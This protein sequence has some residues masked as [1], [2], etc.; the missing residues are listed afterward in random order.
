M[1]RGRRRSR[2][3]VYQVSEC[4]LAPA[5]AASAEIEAKVRREAIA[6]RTRQRTIAAYTNAC[7]PPASGRKCQLHH[8]LPTRR[9]AGGRQTASTSVRLRGYQSNPITLYM[10]TRPYNLPINR[11]CVETT[12]K[13]LPS[14]LCPTYQKNTTDRASSTHSW[15]EVW[16]TGLTRSV[17]NLPFP[18]PQLYV[19]Y[20]TLRAVSSSAAKPCETQVNLFSFSNSSFATR[21]RCSQSQAPTRVQ[22]LLTH[23]GRCKWLHKVNGNSRSQQI[24]NCCR[25]LM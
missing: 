12:I 22:P 17:S 13:I 9:G 2:R 16:A 19:I 21:R 7:A 15:Y 23:A 8:E 5:A 6:A 1:A 4:D 3:P 18:V 10:P 25:V 24:I 11:S 14:T 20:V